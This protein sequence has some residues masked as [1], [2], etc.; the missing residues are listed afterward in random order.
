MRLTLSLIAVLLLAVMESLTRSPKQLYH[1]ILTLM[2]F[3]IPLT[4]FGQAGTRGWDVPDYDGG[5][6]GIGIGGL[7]VLAVIFWLIGRK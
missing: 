2:L 4:V 6:S 3:S 5:G 1:C 7:L